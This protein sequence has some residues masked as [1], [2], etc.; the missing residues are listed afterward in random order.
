MTVPKYTPVDHG[1]FAVLEGLDDWR[2]ILGSIHATFRAGSFGA[3]ASLAVSIAAAAD[4]ADH[5]PAIDV[6]Y[7]D[8]VHVELTTH[9][10]RG[11]TTH[12]VDLARAIS[13]LAAAAGATSEPTLA[14]MVE[15]AIDT[16]DADRIR[17]FWKAVLGYREVSGTLVDPQGRG[18][19]FWFQ[20]MDEA[21][22]ERSRFHIDVIVAHDEAEARI[23]AAL[24]AGGRLVSDAFARSWWVLADV[25]GNE[26]CVCTWQDRD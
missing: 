24:A 13:G 5:H 26:A 8:R 2:V 1:A 16:L 20:D 25:D 10:V 23:A 3:A 22:R 17:P 18:P 9:A 19:S 12:D 4:V 15:V 11:I 6:R 7:P 21:R 14:Q